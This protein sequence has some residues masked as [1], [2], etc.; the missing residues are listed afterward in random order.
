M[1]DTTRTGLKRRTFFFASTG[2]WAACSKPPTGKAPSKLVVSVGPYHTMAP[3]YVAV[4]K[5]YFSQAGLDVE[6]KV[7]RS[8]A[9]MIPLLMQGVLDIT[10]AAATPGLY[11]LVSKG[12]PI[13]ITAAREHL[14]ACQDYGSIYERADRFKKG[15]QDRAA[16][17]GKRIGV[18]TK[19]SIGDFSLDRF[20]KH[21]GLADSALTR[22]HMN[23]AE[24]FAAIIS[25]GID[26]ML[27]SFGLPP[28]F[29]TDSVQMLRNPTP[30]S[31]LEGY[32][33][34]YI[35]FSKRL[36]DADPKFGASFLQPYLKGCHEFVAGF[37]P[38]FLTNFAQSNHIDM[39]KLDSVCRT[40]LALDG[41]IK[42]D[43][44]QAHIDWTVE[45]KY[46][47]KKLEA[48]SMIDTRSLE[49][50]QKETV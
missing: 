19:G 30:L 33:Y 39:A 27:N 24:S 14:T 42:T 44:L 2:I 1:A 45:R 37:T 25:G 18:Q 29:G 49:I 4:E 31:L 17:A 16:W 12:A 48:T 41:A 43:D 15:D 8:S 50:A 7:Q 32:Q 26:A 20:R 9:E 35:L 13:R 36:L 38:R 11:N 22:I 28:D 46:F 47:D 3:F 34:S 5:G 21:I 23:R 6:I 10:L 40:T